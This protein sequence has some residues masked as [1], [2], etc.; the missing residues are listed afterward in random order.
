MS[1]N[2][3]E[4]LSVSKQFGANRIV[5]NINLAVPKG[6]FVSIL[7]PSGCGKTTTLNM[8]AGFERP[9]SG[10]IR[11][12]GRNQAGVPP[13]ARKIG[14][15]F[16]NYALFPHMTVGENVGFGLKM[17]GKPHE[18]ISEEVSRALKSVHL[19][20]FESRYPK[21]LSGGQQQRVAVARAI[22]PSPS[23]LLL[24]EP[25]SNLDLKLR[26]AMRVELKD[27][28][29]E[30]G[31]TFVYVTHDQ[32]EAMAMSDQ[33]IVM[34]EGAVA[35]EGSPA[36]IYNRPKTSFVADF[37]GKSN[38]LPVSGLDDTETGGEC[39]RIFL[40]KEKLP[41]SAVW[42]HNLRPDEARF[43]CIR[44][45]AVRLADA[46]GAMDGPVNL[47]TA[48]VQKVVNLG[49]YLEAWLCVNDEISLKSMIRSTRLDTLVVGSR[50]E[51]AIA[52]STVL[53]LEY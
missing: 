51:L 6:K 47:V 27:I 39:V 32:E 10:E 3:I 22:A 35:Q 19:E 28:Q 9:S 30:L 52:H 12:R 48:T 42:P 29:Q 49:A 26:E 21:E 37:I 38:I 31:I 43:C 53:L 7:G 33:I 24:D 14:L 34:H 25:L 2:D 46:A 44:P 41:I 13:E 16:Q 4:L 17:Q 15:V 11:I 23:V 5:D 50:V 45:E 20:G 18:D 40:G 36:D 1:N 8:I